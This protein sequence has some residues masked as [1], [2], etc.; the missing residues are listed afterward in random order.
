MNRK[1]WSVVLLALFV[2]LV[3]CEAYQDLSNA[4]PEEGNLGLGRRN[5]GATYGRYSMDNE[6]CWQG[7]EPQSSSV[8]VIQKAHAKCMAEKGWGQ[9]PKSSS[10]SDSR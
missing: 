7:I 6:L 10:E 8:A 2:A 1:F 4:P 9:E 5:Y 3:G